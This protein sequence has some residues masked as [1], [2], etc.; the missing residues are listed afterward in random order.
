MDTY[1]TGDGPDIGRLVYNTDRI[2]MKIMKKMKEKPRRTDYDEIIRKLKSMRNPANVEGMARYGISSK[3]TL[4]I[5]IYQLRPMA[6]DIGPDHG[7]ALR[8]WKSGIHEARLL[9]VFIDDPAKV[10]ERQMGEWACDFDSW[11]VCDQ[12]CTSLF[13]QTRFAWK[14]AREWSG[15]NEE[16]VKRGAFAIMAGL[17]VHDKRASDADFAT[18]LPIIEKESADERNFVKKSVNWAL[19]NIGKRNFSLHARALKSAGKI[20][21]RDS[22]AAR[23][24]ANDAIRELSSDKTRKMLEKKNTE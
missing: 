17:A 13:D 22:K 5:S 23:W 20:Q 12:A 21:K 10:T 14:K 6:K 15:R 19:R 11:D 18:L 24:I 9:A 1:H 2:F 3:N 16:F 7:L 8:L 4:G